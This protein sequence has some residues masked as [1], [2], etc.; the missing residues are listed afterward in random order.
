VSPSLSQL[1]GLAEA[2]EELTEAEEKS[3]VEERF[4]RKQSRIIQ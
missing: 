1:L 3:K 4:G 2:K